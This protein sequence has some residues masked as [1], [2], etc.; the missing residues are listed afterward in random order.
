MDWGS[1]VAV[2]C[3][4]GHRR[5]S[6]PAFLWLWYRLAAAALIHPL[7]WELPYAAGAAL[8]RGKKIVVKENQNSQVQEFSDFLCRERCKSLG[9][10]N[11]FL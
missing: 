3:G 5:G 8:K 10:L 4:V 7:A 11:S 1:R 2:S 9:S 6:D